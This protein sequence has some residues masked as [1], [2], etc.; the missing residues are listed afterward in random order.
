MP[1]ISPAAATARALAEFDVN[2]DGF[3]DANELKSSPGLNA[4]GKSMDKDGDGR[5]SA[6]ELRTR[7][8][9]LLDTKV[10]LTSVP[11]KV[12]MYGQ[13]IVNATVKLVPE[14]FLQP[15]L[16]AATGVSDAG[17]TVILKI[18]GET[19]AGIAIG[20]YRAEIS[21]KNAQGEETLPT[22]YNVKTVLGVEVPPPQREG[23]VL[24]L[25]DDD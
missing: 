24:N 23:I 25:T 5:L 9:E 18:E 10:G 19:L 20:F 21:L 4:V 2:Q 17:G 11:C 14:N 15:P 16:R 13:P 8:T 6:E 12:Q 1:D 3:L 22:R 7:L